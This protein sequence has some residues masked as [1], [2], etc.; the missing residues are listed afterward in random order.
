VV[1]GDG[2]DGHAPRGLRLDGPG[3]VLIRYPC[4]ATADGHRLTVAQ[5]SDS[6]CDPAKVLDLAPGASARFIGQRS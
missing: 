3:A 4:E 2:R 1:I 6:P 5:T